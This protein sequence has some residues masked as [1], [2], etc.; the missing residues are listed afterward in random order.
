ML[1]RHDGLLVTFE[2]RQN[3]GELARALRVGWSQIGSL[4]QPAQRLL[5]ALLG[6]ERKTEVETG[7]GIVGRRCK[8]LPEVAPASS[9]RFQLSER[10]AGVHFRGRQGRA[11][12]KSTTKP[13]QPVLETLHANE[14]AT[15][16]VC[17][18]GVL[19]ILLEKSLPAP[20][21]FHELLRTFQKECALP[22]RLDL[23][24]SWSW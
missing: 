7:E 24:G 15:E 23:P 16:F 1:I 6:T 10:D 8:H 4:A 3:L 14:D 12:F 19:R 11:D 21:R 17:S 20:R 9:K 2:C 22:D 13:A 5:V 18:L